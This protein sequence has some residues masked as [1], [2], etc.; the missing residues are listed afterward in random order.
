LAIYLLAQSKNDISAMEL[1]RQLGVKYDTAWL[2]K[3]KIMAA[4]LEANAARKL[5]GDVQ[6]DDAYLGGVRS[7]KGG[8]GSPNKIPFVA[9]VEWRFNH[10]FDLAGAID[11]LAATL[12]GA[13]PAPYRSITL[14]EASG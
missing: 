5:D 1:M 12:L 8:R 3:Q 4:M 14:T 13:K 6:V 11:D 10:R 9:A 7:G 2:M